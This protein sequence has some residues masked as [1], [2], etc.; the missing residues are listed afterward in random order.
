MVLERGAEPL[1]LLSDLP[2]PGKEWILPEM[3]WGQERAHMCLR[4]PAV[5]S[6]RGVCLGASRAPGL[7]RGGCSIHGLPPAPHHGIVVI[8]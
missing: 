1:L 5:I 8:Q 7:P 6:P 2:S 4:F 3:F